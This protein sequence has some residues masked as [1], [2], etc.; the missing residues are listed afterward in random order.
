[1]TPLLSGTDL[2]VLPLTLLA[3]PYRA[4]AW[5]LRSFGGIKP[6]LATWAGIMFLFPACIRLGSPLTA[7]Q[8]LSFPAAWALLIIL[9]YVQMMARWCST[10]PPRDPAS[11]QGWAGDAEPLLTAALCVGMTAACGSGGLLFIL[12]G[13][14]ASEAQWRL[15]RR[16]RSWTPADTESLLAP[17]R[18]G[19]AALDR[20][21]ARLAHAIAAATMAVCRFGW[22]LIA[23][24]RRT[25]T[26]ATAGGGP[27]VIYANPTS[28]GRRLGT[29]FIGHALLSALSGF[30]GF[31]IIAIPFALFLALMGWRIGLPEQMKQDAK[32]AIASVKEAIQDEKDE[33]SER[34]RREREQ[35][36]ERYQEEKQRLQDAARRRWRAGRER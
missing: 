9:A 8:A 21:P 16:L 32:S 22:F 31:K 11:P 13:Y 5:K 34:F 4:L 24:R 26:P 6:G 23:G 35:L 15:E 17:V 12:L 27:V 7:H 2:L 20:L 28:W 33:L 18:R 30:L 19:L 25:P 29:F 3:G 36:E 10:Q 14:A 1:M